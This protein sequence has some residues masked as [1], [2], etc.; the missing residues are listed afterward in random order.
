MEENNRE[1]SQE[2]P[3]E[4][5]KET[6]KPKFVLWLLVALFLIISFLAGYVYLARTDNSL[7]ETPSPTPGADQDDSL[8]RDISN[9][10]EDVSSG[11]GT[12]PTIS[13]TPTPSTSPTNSPTPTTAGPGD[14]QAQPTSTPTPTSGLQLTN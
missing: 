3:V 11:E 5:P 4:T 8:L 13:P 10:E 1:T 7:T 12:S 14:L 9:L 6:K 2:T